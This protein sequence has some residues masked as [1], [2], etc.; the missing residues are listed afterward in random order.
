MMLIDLSILSCVV[1]FPCASKP[2]HTLLRVYLR[3]DFAV[4]YSVF[5]PNLAV[6]SIKTYTTCTVARLRLSLL[7]YN[8]LPL[9][10]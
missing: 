8:P 7:P 1:P 9:A 4:L 3:A 6:V 10:E 2:P 5:A